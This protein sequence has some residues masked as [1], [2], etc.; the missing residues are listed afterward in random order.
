MIKMNT[1]DDLIKEIKKNMDTGNELQN[2][3]YIMNEYKNNDWIEYLSTT[4][5]RQQSSREKQYLCKNNDRK[6]IYQDDMID[7]VLILWE[8]NKESGIHDHP[9]NGC[10]LKILDGELI[11]ELYSKEKH[12]KHIETKE[13][14]KNDC[15]Y[16]EG[17]DILHS[18]KNENKKASISLHI[19][20]PPNY[21]TKYYSDI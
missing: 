10:L 17:D 13:W 20:S 16:I 2:L 12:I 9:K 11:E 15:S 7:V 6:I 19:Y 3:K 18:I 21:K 1:L 4:Q 8:P 5:L 14:I